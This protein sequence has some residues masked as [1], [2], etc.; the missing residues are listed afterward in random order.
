M[1]TEQRILLQD[2]ES[3][4]DSEPSVEDILELLR[5][6]LDTIFKFNGNVYRQIKGTPMGS[7]VS[8]V[9][10]ETVLRDLERMAM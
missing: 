6:C 5:F 3:N 2:G 7:P 9:I 1:N 8:G 4:E 10:A